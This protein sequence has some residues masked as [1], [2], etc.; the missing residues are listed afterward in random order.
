MS[1]GS[2]PALD[3]DLDF[4]IDSGGDIDESS[5]IDEL[6]KD[7]SVQLIFALEQFLGRPP[8]ASVKSEVKNVTTQTLSADSRVQFVSSESIDVDIDR[9]SKNIDIDVSIITID[10]EEFDLVFEV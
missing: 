10:G 8:T 1:F 7:L 9:I 2:G 3:E 6:T 5:G 4:S